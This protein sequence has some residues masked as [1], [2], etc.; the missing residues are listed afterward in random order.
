MPKAEP[1]VEPVSAQASF[2]AAEE[3]ERLEELLD[4]LAGLKSRLRAARQR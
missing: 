4:E 2:L 3:R 1:V